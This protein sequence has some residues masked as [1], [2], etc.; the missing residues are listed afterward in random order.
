MIHKIQI[1]I[2]P[3]CIRRSVY[4][5]SQYAKPCIVIIAIN[6]NFLLIWLFFTSAYGLFSF[7]I[8]TDE[9]MLKILD[10]TKLLSDNLA[11]NKI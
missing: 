8:I 5:F 7:E 1:N 3:I 4:Q 6:L 2:W 9:K 11:F 10:N